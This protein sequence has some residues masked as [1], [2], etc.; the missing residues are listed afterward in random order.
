MFVLLVSWTAA[1]LYLI[2]VV[3]YTVEL[4]EQGVTVFQGFLRRQV[5]W[6]DA[7]IAEWKA[8][9]TCVEEEIT[10][11]TW[12]LEMR[13]A[14]GQVKLRVDG[15]MLDPHDRRLLGHLVLRK[16]EAGRDREA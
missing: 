7:F 13:D 6:D 16:L 15:D 9:H 14:A 8:R 5:L 2:S 10:H 1:L 4:D 12:I 11:T 3:R